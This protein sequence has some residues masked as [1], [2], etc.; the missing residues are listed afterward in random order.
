MAVVPDRRIAITHKLKMLRTNQ[1]IVS[2][3]LQK[4]IKSSG[5]DDKKDDNINTAAGFSE[6]KN[7]VEDRS[8]SPSSLLEPNAFTVR[9]LQSLLRNLESEIALNEQHLHDENDKRYM[10]K[11]RN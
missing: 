7:E 10:F 4:L 1:A 5:N 9:D 3:T 2:A 6:T 8:S 11:V